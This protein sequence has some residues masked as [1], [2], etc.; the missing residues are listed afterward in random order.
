MDLRNWEH[1]ADTGSPVNGATVEARLASL[2]SPNVGAVVATTTTNADGMW[3]FAGLADAPH[4]IKV[5]YL[6]QTWW[7]KGLSRHSTSALFTEGSAQ[8]ALQFPLTRNG[9]MESWESGVGPIALSA[10]IQSVAD[11]WLS[12][13]TGGSSGSITKETTIKAPDSLASAKLIFN[14]VAGSLFMQFNLPTELV[15]ALRGKSFT[16]SAQARQ[17]VASS[18]RLYIQDSAGTTNSSTNATTGSFITHT[19]TRTIDANA[20]GLGYGLEITAS[21]TVYLDNVVDQIGNVA[22]VYAPNPLDAFLATELVVVDQ[23]GVATSSINTLQAT[24]NAIVGRLKAIA[25]T[26]NW[27]DN[28]VASLATLNTN[29][30]SLSS[31]LTASIATKV[32]KAGDTMTGALTIIKN[33]GAVDA[34]TYARAG[35]TVNTS[36]GSRPAISFSRDGVGAAAFYWEANS[37]LGLINN[38]GTAV[39]ILT[40]A[41]S[42]NASTLSGYPAGNGSSNIPISNGATV[43]NLNADMVD[44]IH[45]TSMIQTSTAGNQTISSN[46]GNLLIGIIPSGPLAGNSGAFVTGSFA[47][48]GTKN[49][50]ATGHDGVQGVLHSIET[51]LPMFEEY[52][53]AQLLHGEAVVR[54]PE[55]FANYVDLSDYYIQVTA[56]GPALLYIA[57]RTPED[58]VVRS[59]LGDPEASFTWHLVAGQGDMTHITRVLP[60]AGA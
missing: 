54:I 48:S 29:I 30:S 13:V 4:D 36:D 50:I 32:A 3:T 58:F 37:V 22:P 16:V 24:L 31:T 15:A 53:R 56:E 41:S 2:T 19:V 18:S 42:V 39:T 52:G 33:T 46:G 40:T 35:L 38:G 23:A 59:L 21:D 44:G 55:D 34:N 45:G 43:S 7:Y 9:G 26:T 49:R 5:T 11:Q 20:T 60:T 28:A 1:F 12:W 57:E 25:G 10:S 27:Y 6:T 17:G 47:A 8:S 14:R 51:P